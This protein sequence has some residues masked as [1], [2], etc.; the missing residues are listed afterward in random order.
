M[1]AGK[2]HSFSLLLRD[3]LRNARCLA[4]ALRE[5][6][7]DADAPC[8]YPGLFEAS[9]AVQQHYAQKAMQGDSNVPSASDNV[10]RYNNLIKTLLVERFVD[11]LLGPVRVLDV[12]CGRGQDLQKYSREFR[13]AQIS[14]YVGLDFALEA[15]QEARRRY[16]KIARKGE[17]Q[18]LAA[19]YVGDLR[20][21]A[22]FDQLAG[23][24]HTRFDVVSLQFTLQYL[25]DSAETVRG[26]FAKLAGLL[27][28]G[29]RVIGCI[30]SSDVLLDLYSRPGSGPPEPPGAPR[31]R[32]NALYSVLFRGEAWSSVGQSEGDLEE[33]FARRWGLPY[34]FSLVD[35]VDA[36][37]EYVVPWE[38]LEELASSVGFR[39]AADAP[40]A[41]VLAEYSGTSPFYANFFSKDDRVAKLSPQEEELFGF[42]SCFVFERE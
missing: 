29:G 26:L 25:A 22:S 11:P 35:A 3:L 19:F 32:G 18:Y 40:F 28:P 14:S 8:Y 7:G 2:A 17:S 6:A 39:V 42:Y 30:P 21:P 27:R 38:A 23:G 41:D 1:Q 13:K 20:D 4:A 36:L 34:A 9:V 33:A 24:G 31:R 10:R 15:V 5:A 37:E 12:G 16:A